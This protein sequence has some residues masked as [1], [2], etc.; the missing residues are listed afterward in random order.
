VTKVVNGS[1]V[2]TNVTVGAAQN[3]ETQITSGVASGDKVLEREITFKAPGGAGGIL[4]G[5]T[6]TARRFGGAGGFGG[7][8]AGGFGGGGGFTTTGGGGGFGG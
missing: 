1:H 4:G 5:G 3:G 7:G 2:V 6:G 8:G